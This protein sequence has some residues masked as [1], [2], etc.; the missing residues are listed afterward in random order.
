MT[1]IDGISTELLEHRIALPTPERGEQ[2]ALDAE[3]LLRKPV[4]VLN[5]ALRGRDYL[6]GA[7]FSAADL[8]V[9]AVVSVLGF[10][11]MDLAPYSALTDWLDRCLRRPARAKVF[12]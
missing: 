1:E 9:A 8:N 10:A 11:R 4:A 5:D 2:K 7:E 12:G 6:L 3:E